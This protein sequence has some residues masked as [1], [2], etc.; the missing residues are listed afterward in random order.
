VHDP[1]R[2]AEPMI[3]GYRPISPT[4]PILFARYQAFLQPTPPAGIEPVRLFV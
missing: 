1:Y 2:E 4:F 3:V